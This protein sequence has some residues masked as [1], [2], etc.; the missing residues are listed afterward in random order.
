MW[1]KQQ[2]NQ[3]KY[4]I[5]TLICTI[6]DEWKL[7]LYISLLTEFLPLWH[8]IS[9]LSSSKCYF[10]LNLPEA[11]SARG[12]IGSFPVSCAPIGRSARW[13]ALI[14]WFSGTWY[15][16]GRWGMMGRKWSPWPCAFEPWSWQKI[17]STSSR[18]WWK[19]CF[20]V[21]LLIFLP[22]IFHFHISYFWVNHGW[23][24]E[25]VHLWDLI[26]TIN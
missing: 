15:V 18:F 9:H 25:S 10:H 13:P 11:G 4:E 5:T 12:S 19:L 6:L 3:R 26:A 14:G 21:A 17:K 20:K 1:E 7:K 8:T 22:K 2:E 24:H 16:G 23:A